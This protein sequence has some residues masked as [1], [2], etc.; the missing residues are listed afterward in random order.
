MGHDSY[1]SI[2]ER[3]NLWHPNLMYED[4]VLIVMGLILYFGKDSG[5]R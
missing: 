1:M 2:Y 4:T 5:G 3:R